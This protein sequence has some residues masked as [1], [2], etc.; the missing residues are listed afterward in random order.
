MENLKD[1][2]E[3]REDKEFRKYMGEI[4]CPNCGRLLSEDEC[5]YDTIDRCS[6][7]YYCG[8]EVSL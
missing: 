5:E 3:V 8:V 2:S 6:R 7:C 4:E 1:P